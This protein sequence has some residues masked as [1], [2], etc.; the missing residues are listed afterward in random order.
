MQKLHYTTRLVASPSGILTKSY[1]YNGTTGLL[2]QITTPEG[3]HLLT[4]TTKDQLDTIS[5]PD[6]VTLNFDYDSELIDQKVQTSSIVDYFKTH[7]NKKIPDNNPNL[8]PVI[9]NN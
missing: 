5:S 9:F 6:S 1:S 2:S 7:C 3:N 4:Y 8:I